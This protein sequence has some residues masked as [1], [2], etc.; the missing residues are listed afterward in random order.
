MHRSDLFNYL[1]DTLPEFIEM[2]RDSYDPMELAEAWNANLNCERC[3]ADLI[4]PE[5][6]EEQTYD[7]YGMDVLDGKVSSLIVNSGLEIPDL[8]E[9][10]LCCACAH[11]KHKD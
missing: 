4:D 6:F 8:E 1:P 9:S 10:G 5:Y 2:L 3:G 11:Q 7:Y